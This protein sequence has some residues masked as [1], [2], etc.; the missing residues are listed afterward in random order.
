MVF[1]NFVTRPHSPRE[2]VLTKH[3]LSILVWEF[4]WLVRPADSR[5]SSKADDILNLGG[6]EDQTLV[7]DCGGS[8]SLFLK[9]LGTCAKSIIVGR[10]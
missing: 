4:A 3:I 10:W 6:N 8:V 7:H 5:S 1:A 2:H 9:R